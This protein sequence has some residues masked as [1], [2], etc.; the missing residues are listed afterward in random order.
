MMNNKNI[1]SLMFFLFISSI[2]YG[3]PLIV[4]TIKPL[5][6][7]INEIT[8]ERAE[9]Y[10]LIPPDRSIHFYEFKASDIKKLYNSD[11]FVYIGSGEPN[12]DGL[13]SNVK[14]KKIKISEIDN[15]KLIYKFE[16]LH[17]DHED[18]HHHSGKEN[19]H[20][21]FYL[22]PENS[23][24]F[25]EYITKEIIKLDKSGKNY[26]LKRKQ[27]FISRLAEFT[28]KWRKKIKSLDNKNFIS[29]H[30]SWPYLTKSFGLNYIDVI[31]LGHGREPT[32]KHLLEVIK[33]IKK[34]KIKTVFSAKQFY[35]RKYLDILSKETG[36][37]IVLLD[38]FGINMD[39][40]G[41][42]EFN[43]KNIFTNL[44]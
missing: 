8:G 30:Y 3:K 27:K 17:T 43:L 13:L 40:F 44:K 23:K 2:T 6:D 36:V 16:F 41:M 11:I 4:T 32:P 18:H 39:F 31:E 34:Y 29:Y 12:I 14:N 33:K 19:F 22:D 24:I 21:L 28:D 25:A 7:I 26:Y 15:I 37:K 10:Y 5:A 35:N 42:M 9:V 38:P 1:L 20:P